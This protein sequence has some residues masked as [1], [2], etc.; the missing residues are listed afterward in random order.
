MVDVKNTESNEKPSKAMLELLS[1]VNEIAAKATDEDREYVKKISDRTRA[2][3]YV[4][5]TPVVAALIATTNNVANRAAT[6]SRC[7]QYV[8]IMRRGDWRKH[9]QGIAFYSDGTLADGQHRMVSTALS[10]TT[11][12]FLVVCDFA[13]SSIDGID[14]TKQRTA[15]EA[16]EMLAVP[17]AK[18]K[19]TIA[20][21]AMTY[22]HKQRTGQNKTFDDPAIEKWV[23]DH[24]DILT[25]AI[26]IGRA[27]VENVSSPALT[28][29]EAARIATLMLLG[30][31]QKAHVVRYIAS[32]QE[33]SAPYP[34]A[35]TLELSRRLIKAKVAE[36][37][38]DRITGTELLALSLKAARLWVNGS[39]VSK[40]T[41]NA[42]KEDLPDFDNPAP[43]QQQAA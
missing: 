31:W 38:K 34:Q 10:G 35:P 29:T 32:I 23:L 11:Q 9:H 16:L 8:G 13:K 17:F 25:V 19:A 2:P 3:G 7:I 26:D 37:R 28:Q 27:S 18:V 40:L 39:S 4:K 36:N 6:A 5:I 43:E 20:K 1:Q 15:G 14:R 12:E 24:D 42:A 30:N 22:A 21:V 33:G 41:W